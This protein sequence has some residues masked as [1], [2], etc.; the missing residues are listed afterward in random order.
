MTASTDDQVR[1][2]F[3]LVD[4]EIARRA[5]V[6]V[7]CYGGRSR[8]GAVLGCWLAEQA[9]VDDAID[10]LNELRDPQIDY[11]RDWERIPQ[12]RDQRELVAR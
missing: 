3:D 12:T 10:H 8:T 9:D 1:E 11:D 6:Y 2:V 7:H 5:R 4:G